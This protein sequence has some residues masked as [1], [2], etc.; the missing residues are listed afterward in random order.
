MKKIVLNKYLFR[1]V[2]VGDIIKRIN[3][4]IKIKLN[5]KWMPEET[6]NKGT[7]D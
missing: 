5:I 6:V 2:N 3:K 4:L 1:K 7:E